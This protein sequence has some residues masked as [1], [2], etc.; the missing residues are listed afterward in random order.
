MNTVQLR[1]FMAVAETLNFAKA[2]EIMNITQP[3]VTQQI[4][5]LEDELGARLFKRSTRSVELTA[6]GQIFI[7]DAQS[8]LDIADRAGRRFKEARTEIRKEFRIGCHSASEIL[9]LSSAISALHAAYPYIYP[10]FRVNPFRHLYKELE[11]GKLDAVISFKEGVPGEKMEFIGISSSRMMA[12]V[13][14][15]HHLARKRGIR[16][17]DLASERLVFIDPRICP[18]MINSIQLSISS[19]HNASDIFFSSAPEGAEVMAA[20]GF[21]VAVLPELCLSGQKIPRIP[22]MGIDSVPFGIYIRRELRTP[23]LQSFLSG[24]I[25]RSSS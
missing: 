1:S 17:A 8:M 24:M 19:N 4:H 11:E 13:P 16:A 9:L 20:S 3:A 2:A 12:V 10:V 21:G 25:T 18:E 6:E 23:E 22:I 14:S 7:N 5:A 15:F